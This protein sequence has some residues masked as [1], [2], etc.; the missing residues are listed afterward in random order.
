[1]LLD[2]LWLREC[3][4][5]STLNQEGKAYKCVEQNIYWHETTPG[6]GNFKYLDKCFD[7]YTIYAP[8]DKP[9]SI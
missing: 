2:I 3:H 5:N 4:K 9:I 8:M 7:K 6:D 1:M